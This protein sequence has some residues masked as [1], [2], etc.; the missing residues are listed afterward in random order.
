MQETLTWLISRT[1]LIDPALASVAV[2][3]EWSLLAPL[4]KSFH[5]DYHD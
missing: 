2:D 4:A 5:R 3:T 1:A